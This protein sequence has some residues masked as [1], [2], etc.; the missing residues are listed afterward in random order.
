MSGIA[1]VPGN[2]SHQ[3]VADLQAIA[4]YA[5]NSGALDMAKGPSVPPLFVRDIELAVRR[6]G[7]QTE[8]L[9]KLGIPHPIVSYKVGEAVLD[10]VFSGRSA[11]FVDTGIIDTLQSAPLSN[12]SDMAF[13]A[14]QNAQDA[15][16][17][18]S[19]GS[20]PTARDTFQRD[21]FDFLTW[22]AEAATGGS[23]G[24]S[25]GGTSGGS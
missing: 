12:I 8:L 4:A 19:D 11:P 7:H 15:G 21:L 18:I 20:T 23:G 25:S 3:V 17:K 9:E 14:R 2:L 10:V 1:R 13:A 5:A 24:G 16:F 6:F 22:R